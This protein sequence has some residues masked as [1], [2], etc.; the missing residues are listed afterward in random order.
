MKN[1]HDRKFAEIKGFY[2][3]LEKNIFVILWILLF[4]MKPFNLEATSS[5][6]Y[7]RRVSPKIVKLLRVADIFKIYLI[8]KYFKTPHDII[9][10]P[11]NGHI[12]IKTTNGLKVFNLLKDTVV[13][14]YKTSI[15]EGDFSKIVNDLETISKYKIS[16]EVIKVNQTEK[17][18]YEEYY[19]YY[20]ADRFYP[21]T[22]YYYDNILPLLIRNIN[23][24]PLKKVLLQDYL[25]GIKQSVNLERFFKV[26]VDKNNIEFVN[27]YLKRKINEMISLTNAKTVIVSFSH[28][29]LHAWNILIDSKGAKIIDWDT[30]DERSIY[31]DL[32]Y[33]LF[34]NL[35]GSNEKNDH[36]EFIGC[37]NN[38]LIS[39]NKRVNFKEINPIFQETDLY[40]KLFY[41]EYIKMYYFKKIKGESNIEKVRKLMKNLT[42]DIIVFEEIENNYKKNEVPIIV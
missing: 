4:K 6:K 9:K 41:L 30:I 39:F 34:H 37:L 24:F 35:F 40:R 42:K 17:F 32:F 15:S 1:S 20:K 3:A 2:V 7:L 18:I 13:T 22:S 31:F 8:C 38:I 33:S 11:F 12:L 21:V 23:M 26:E 29:D 5:S 27:T 25:E 16:P 10:S 36:K 28:G 14:Q 19:N